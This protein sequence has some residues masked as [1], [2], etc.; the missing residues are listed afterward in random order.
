[1]T[2]LNSIF[3]NIPALPYPSIMEFY[4]TLLHSMPKY[5]I[6]AR[7]RSIKSNRQNFAQQLIR[8]EYLYTSGLQ[9]IIDFIS[10]IIETV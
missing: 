5:D 1:M 6:S 10:S 2:F 9:S 8:T 4:V 3:S 7:T